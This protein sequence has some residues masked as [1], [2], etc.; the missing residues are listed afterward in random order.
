MLF[1]RRFLFSFVL[2]FEQIEARAKETSKLC[3]QIIRHRSDDVDIFSPSETEPIAKARRSVRI[4][5]QIVL[6]ENIL[7]AKTLCLPLTRHEV[8]SDPTKAYNPRRPC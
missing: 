5:R 3:G 8:H 7:Q 2:S 1:I 4:E 6:D